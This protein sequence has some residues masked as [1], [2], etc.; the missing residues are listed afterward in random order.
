M[1][2]VLMIVA[3]AAFGMV[4]ALATSL[5]AGAKP[6]VTIV[7]AKFAGNIPQAQT[8]CD[9]TN[10][11]LNP[12][13]H[14][15]SGIPIYKAPS[16]QGCL[17]GTH[18]CM[19]IGSAV[20][21]NNNHTIQGVECVD[22]WADSLIE[23]ESVASAYCQDHSNGDALVQCANIV[24][25]FELADPGNTFSADH[26][27]CGHSLGACN[28][29]RNFLQGIQQEEHSTSCSS[30]SPNEWWGVDTSGGTIELP[31]SDHT[32]TS[33]SNLSSGHGIPCP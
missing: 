27:Q 32:V 30:G 3:V 33:T 16:H 20:N 25:P 23:V 7:H 4:C 10:Q 11:V 21:P 31:G 8:T 19:I 12:T 9:F 15:S 13:G 2:R 29:G 6:V 22:G 17:S 28:T 1:R 26:L 14:T 18:K 5:P 24:I